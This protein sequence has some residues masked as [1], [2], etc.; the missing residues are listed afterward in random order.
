MSGED[1]W[2]IIDQNPS[3]SQVRLVTCCGLLALLYGLGY[4]LQSSSRI[5]SNFPKVLNL[6]RLSFKL[7]PSVWGECLGIIG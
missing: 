1:Y 5:M 7:N 6:N 4:I 3:A 2:G